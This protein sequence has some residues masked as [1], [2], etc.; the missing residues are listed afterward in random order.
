MQAL[1]FSAL[2]AIELAACRCESCWR[3]WLMMA[4]YDWGSIGS[5]C[6]VSPLKSGGVGGW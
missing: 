4:G 1:N 6:A 5:V 2:L 3:P